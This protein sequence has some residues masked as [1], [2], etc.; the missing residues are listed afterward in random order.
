MEVTAVNAISFEVP[1]GEFFGLLGPNG[2]GKMTTIRMLTSLTK[3]TSGTAKIAGQDCVRD[4][5]AVKNWRFS[6]ST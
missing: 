6:H 3:P 4:S 1:R 5:L 2:A